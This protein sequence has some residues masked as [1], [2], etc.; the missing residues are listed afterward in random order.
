ML[1]PSNPSAPL[2]QE[3]P[4]SKALSERYLA[5]ALSTITSR[6]LPDARDGMKPVHRRLLFAMRELK[7]NPASGF[8]KCARIVGDVMGKY[9]PHGDQAIYDAMVRLAQDFAVRYPLVEGQGN[10]GNIDG[11]NPAAM[12]YTEARLTLTALQM[13]EGIDEDMVDFRP[14][15]DSEGEEPVVLPAA[16]PNLLANGSSGIAV[17]MATNIPPH[18]ILE[19]CDALTLLIQKP[20]CEIEELLTFIKGPDFPT[21]G[22]MI[23]TPESILNTYKTGRGSFRVRANYIVEKLANGLYEVIIDQIPYQV[24]K[25]KLIERLAELAMGKENPL[26]EDVRD[27]SA[28][29]IRI[30]LTPKSRNIPPELLMEAL[31]RQSDLE[32]RFAM[33]MNMLVEKGASPKLLDLKQ[34]LQAFLDHRQDVLCRRIRHRQGTIESRLHILRGYII[35]HLNI[36]EVIKIIREEDEPKPALMARF[37]L[38]DIQSEAILNMR[39]RQLRRLEEFALTKESNEL[40]AELHELN[41]LGADEGARWR[42]IS[43]EI[44][45]LKKSYVKLPDLSKRRTILSDPPKVSADF[46]EDALIEKEPI[47]VICSQKGWIRS[48]RGH[49]N[50]EALAQI[51]YKDGDE[52]KLILNCQTTDKVLLFATNGRVYSLNADK[53]PAGRGTG[54]PY[55]LMIELESEYDLID[56]RI[57]QAEQKLILASSDGYGFII[58]QKNLFAQTR[59]GKQVMN[60]SPNAELAKIVDI[61]GDSIAVIGEGRKLLIFALNELPEMNKG[62]GVRLQKYT[63]GGLADIKCFTYEEGLSWAIGDRERLEKTLMP[64]VGKRAQSGRLPPPGFPRSNRFR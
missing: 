18:N 52:A 36:D 10:F 57:Y 31:Y 20:H 62:R 39:L 7:L 64:W 46:S 34:A 43:G 8:K 16:F 33:N 30:V 25:S 21:G 19:L 44:K 37:D 56:I 40:T 17:G 2:V 13:M 55:R 50:Q 27:E 51:K 3:T 5:Y 41:A 42:K 22:Q 4:L 26:L 58:E 29:D 63:T 1:K 6:S 15:Y 61:S 11:D 24:Q 45:E 60:L 59:N 23:E 28:Q 35:C 14:T 38:D 53:L 54:E 9:H 47:T 32:S 12:R 48:H 49:L